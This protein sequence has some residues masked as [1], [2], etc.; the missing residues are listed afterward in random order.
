MPSDR[1]LAIQS[2]NTNKIISTFNFYSMKKILSIFLV[3]ATL[4]CV[5]GCDKNGSNGKID[6]NSIYLLG[7]TKKAMSETGLGHSGNNSF[8]VAVKIPADYVSPKGNKKV[9]GVRFYVYEGAESGKAFM[10]YEL[11]TNVAEKAFTYTEGGWQ[12]VVFDEP[13]TIN[14]GA[15]IYV[16]YEVSGSGYY[17]GVEENSTLRGNSYL[18]EDGSW[19]TFKTVGIS[20]YGASIQAICVGGDYSSEIQHD[21]VVENLSVNKNVRAG[22]VVNF[23]AEVRNAGI[24][25]TGTINVV[26]K[27]GDQVVNETATALRNGE[28]KKFNFTINGIGVDMTKITVEATEADVTDEK[29]ANNKASQDINVYAADAPER[30]CILIEEFTSQSCPNCPAGIENLREAIAGM[31][32]PEKAAWVAHHSGYADDIFTLTGDKTIATK[33]GCNFAPACCIDRME[34]NYSGSTTELIW[35]PGY[36]YSSLL[37][38]LASIPANATIAMDVDFD[39]TDSTLTVEL[40]GMSYIHDCYMT[41]I[42]CQNGVIASQSNGG[43]NFEHNEI[44]RAY[45]TDAVGDKLTVDEE[46]GAYTAE[47]SYKIP[48]SISGVKSTAVATDIPNMYVVAFIHGKTASKGSV[49]NAIKA[50]IVSAPQ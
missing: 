15:D 40:N 31:Q 30:V 26:A 17:I 36:A 48:A 43:S 46:T 18:Y 45:M 19:Q 38:E 8:K 42:V 27:Y 22:E 20:Y 11:G 2:I 21:V 1:K 28:S 49:Y 47:Y 5:I 29:T 25:T 9:M 23:S 50:N 3:A 35:H 24:K 33:L 34:V 12:Y 37:D 14:E 32:H 4:L 16:G 7:Q 10:A 39:A 41:V 13:V 6:M 44:V